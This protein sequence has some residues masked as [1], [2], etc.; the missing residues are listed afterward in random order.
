MHRPHSS[1]G[2][3]LPIA[4]AL[5]L[6]ACSD[7]TTSAPPAIVCGQTLSNSPAGAVVTDASSSD[8]TVTGQTSGGVVLLLSKDC[9]QGARIQ[10]QPGHAAAATTEIRTKDG[11]LAAVAL[12]PAT[13]TT[14]ADVV[15][16]HANGRQ[17]IVR[18]RLGVP[19]S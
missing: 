18:I 12:T 2:Y 6:P 1:I 14:N 15:V 9:S 10:I 4:L 17:T 16:R 11:N 3:A 8:V 7:K 13:P 19:S 5:V